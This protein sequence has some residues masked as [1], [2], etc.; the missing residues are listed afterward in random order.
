[1]K[2]RLAYTT[3]RIG[4]NETRIMYT[5]RQASHHGRLDSSRRCNVMKAVD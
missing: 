5:E 3:V 2:V 4:V 1:M